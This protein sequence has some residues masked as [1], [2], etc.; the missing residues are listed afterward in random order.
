[1]D[2]SFSSDLIGS[3]SQIKLKVYEE[4]T[5]LSEICFFLQNYIELHSLYLA[6]SKSILTPLRKIIETKNSDDSI[7]FFLKFVIQSIDDRIEESENYINV[8]MN[9]TYKKFMDFSESYQKNFQNINQE[10]DNAFHH[11]NEIEGRVIK[12]KCEFDE[13]KLTMNDIS[14]CKQSMRNLRRANYENPDNVKN[15]ITSTTIKTKLKQYEYLNEVE[16][17]NEFVHQTKARF[18]ELFNKIELIEKNRI[19]FIK[20]TMSDF[21]QAT[22]SNQNLFLNHIIVHLFRTLLII[23]T[24]LM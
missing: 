7:S 19:G 2:R 9:S 23:L 17:F 1:M 20:D 16:T 5:L 4:S 6:K 3:F 12:L 14:T 8:S 10:I 22:L 21:L 15:K 18:V 13:F 24:L 11:Y